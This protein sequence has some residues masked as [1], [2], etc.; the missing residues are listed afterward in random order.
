MRSV[1]SALLL[2]LLRRGSRLRRSERIARDEE[3]E[4]CKRT[5]YGGDDERLAKSEMSVGGASHQTNWT[6]R[7]KRQRHVS[8]VRHRS[9][10][11]EST[12]HRILSAHSCEDV[13]KANA[14]RRV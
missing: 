2:L 13:L 11:S 14:E 9:T 5:Q 12:V 8:K 4:N 1:Y 7:E 10:R 3:E 6:Y